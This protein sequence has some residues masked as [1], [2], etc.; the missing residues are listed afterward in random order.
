[1]TLRVERDQI[2]GV[3]S[4]GV[5]QDAVSA[6]LAEHRLLLGRMCSVLAHDLQG[7]LNSMVLNLELLQR[8]A[9]TEPGRVPRYA[10]LIASELQSLDKRL[11]AVVGQMR[12]ADPPT[13]QFDL[14]A[15]TDELAVVFESYARTRRVRVRS[16]LPQIP[17]NVFGDRDAV[18]HVFTSLLVGVVDSLPTGSFLSLALRTDRQNAVLDISATPGAGADTSGPPEPIAFWTREPAAGALEAARAVLQSDHAAPIRI[19]SGPRESARLQI[20]LPLAPLIA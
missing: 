12:L 10:S 7:H 18:N 5:E 16:T 11:K 13:D 2:T 8:T 15:V 20:E 9:E 19:P 3:R 6:R 14:R 4:E 17:V 1:L